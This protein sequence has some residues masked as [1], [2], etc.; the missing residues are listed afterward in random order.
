MLRALRWFDH[1]LQ[2]GNHRSDAPPPLDLDYSASD[3]VGVEIL[4]YVTVQK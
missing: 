2:P 3:D 1:Y 4:K